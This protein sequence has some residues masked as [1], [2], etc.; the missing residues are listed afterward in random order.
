MVIGILI[1]LMSMATVFSFRVGDWKAGR[2][3]SETLRSVYVAQRTYLAD[4]PTTP[5]S[6]LTRSALLP[7]IPQSPSSFPTVEGLD[8]TLRQIKVTVSPPVVIDTSGTVYD[9]SGNPKDSLWDVGE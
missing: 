7:Y 6:T 9:P 8:G 2:E 3:A 5:V 1:A 4:N